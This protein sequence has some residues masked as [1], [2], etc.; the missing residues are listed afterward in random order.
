MVNPVFREEEKPLKIRVSVHQL[1]SEFFWLPIEPNSCTPYKKVAKVSHRLITPNHK[2]TTWKVVLDDHEPLQTFTCLQLFR[3]KYVVVLLCH[4]GNFAG[5]VFDQNGKVV[6]HKTI[7]K[8]ITRKKQGRRQSSQDKSKRARSIGSDIRR[9]NE[10]HFTMQV[11]EL[12]G[13]TWR[14]YIDEAGVI[15]CHAP[16]HNKVQILCFEKGPF[17]KDDYRLRNIPFP[18]EQPNFTQ[19]QKVYQKLMTVVIEEVQKNQ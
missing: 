4:G 17:E 19:V 9:M 5:A 13:K 10:L 16:G 7:H 6:V 12:I 14:E 11:Q 1:P 15:F 18:T 2:V 3:I 8:Y